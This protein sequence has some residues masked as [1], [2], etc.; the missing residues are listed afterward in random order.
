MSVLAAIYWFFVGALSI[1]C[2]EKD[3]GRFDAWRA[4]GLALAW[5]VVL[6]VMLPV[7]LVVR[8]LGERA[9]RAAKAKAVP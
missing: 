3:G 4:L 6:G 1:T 7:A 9:E 8:W 5:P 2:R